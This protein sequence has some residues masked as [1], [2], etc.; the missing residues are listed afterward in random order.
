M[1][2]LRLRPGFSLLEMVVSV[3]LFGLLMGLIFYFMR[4]GSQ[5]YYFAQTRASVQNQILAVKNAVANDL[6]RAHFLGVHRIQVDKVVNTKRGDT[7]VQTRRDIMSTV[8]LSK[9]VLG[10]TS[11]DPNEGFSFGGL[12]VWDCFIVYR[13]E[14]AYEPTVGLSRYVL[15]ND[16]TKTPARALG[17]PASFNQFATET[18]T[19]AG[20][21][22][23]VRVGK[24]AT[25]VSHFEVG[26]DNT[27]QI[28]TLK[29]RVLEKTGDVTNA[30][31]ENRKETTALFSFRP[32]N[33]VPRL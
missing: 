15:F 24:V 4:M 11:F 3:A 6:E 5:G 9:W 12:P 33:T 22:S 14:Q 21:P 26:L 25:D 2:L 7:T 8:A 17:N 16:S 31:E 13:P 10:D 18:F 29:V 32:Y 20:V 28:V 19:T 27:R 1:R 30:I 23:I